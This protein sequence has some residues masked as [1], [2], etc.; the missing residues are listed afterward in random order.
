MDYE[1]TKHAKLRLKERLIRES[2]IS[3]ALKK[4][5]RISKDQQGV[6]LYKKLYRRANKLKLLIIAGK[7]TQG[8]FKIFTIIETSKVQKH[9]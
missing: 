2:L 3:E 9:L 4:P 8:T 6:L 1:L 7:F 5:D